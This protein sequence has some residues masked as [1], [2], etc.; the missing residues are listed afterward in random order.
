MRL[1]PLSP[2]QPW[3]HSIQVRAALD[4]SLRGS[5]CFLAEEARSLLARLLSVLSPVGIK[6][7]LK[8]LVS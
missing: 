8:P 6:T 7:D 3:G 2:D 5:Q 4:P 1:A